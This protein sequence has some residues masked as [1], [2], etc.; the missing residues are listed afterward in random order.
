MANS[1]PN[2]NGSQVSAWHRLLRCV[3]PDPTFASHTETPPPGISD[4]R[5]LQRDLSNERVA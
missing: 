1:G 2:T 3:A 5:D 4:G